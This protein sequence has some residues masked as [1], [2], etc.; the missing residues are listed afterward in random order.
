MIKVLHL[1]TTLDNGGVE[2]FLASYYRHIDRDKIQFDFVVPSFNEG[3]L[4]PEMKKLGGRVFHIHRLRANPFKH[5]TDL[6]RI[7]SKGNYDVIHCHG[8]KSSIGLFIAKIVGCRVRVLHSHMAYVKESIIEKKVRQLLTTLS[9]CV[10]TNLFA[11]GRD[12]ARWLFGN[13]RL[14]TGLVEIIPNAIELDK[15]S[16]SSADREKVRQELQIESSFVLGNV[17][18]LSNQKNQIF[19]LE[20]MR[21]LIPICPDI[22]LLLI[23]DGEDQEMLKEYCRT[24]CLA[25]SVRFLGRRKDI[26]VLLSAI[27][28]FVLP[29]KFEG[30]PVSLVEA[31]SAGLPIL[32]SD[33]ITREV[34][35]MN[36]I[37]YLP[38]GRN[39][40]E[41]WKKTVEDLKQKHT[42]HSSASL[43]GSDY[44]IHHQARKL[45]QWYLEHCGGKER[46]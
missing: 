31:Q 37:T 20:M 41:E 10:A 9:I 28:L 15:Y 43:Y 21:E 27:D 5:L 4:E 19:L 25:D 35:L 36:T 2:T 6:F 3:F 42:R 7:I 30:L 38:I 13:K 39:G 22:V 45:S 8:Y 24:L 46:I 32:A 1:F 23:G 16:F 12:A 40:Q 29:S 33:T 34:D 26:P 44:D 17:A 18:R 11:C 14:T